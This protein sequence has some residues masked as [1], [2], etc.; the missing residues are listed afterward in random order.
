[1]VDHV[2]AAPAIPINSDDYVAVQRLINRYADA[3]VHRN[4]TQWASCWAD[5]ATWDLGRGRLVEGKAAIVDLWYSAMKGMAAVFQVVQ[6]GEV[7]AGDHADHATGR[8]YI[9]ER[10]RRADGTSGTLLAHYDDAYVRVDGQWL[11]SRRFLQPHYA[12]APDL[13]SD[14]SNTLD[15]LQ[16]RG[17]DSAD[18]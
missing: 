1:M 11:F 4:G 15:A 18:A 14:F 3:V 10:F 8:W 6:N 9:T 7:W 2:P 17:V 13:S 12:G 5:D 16:A